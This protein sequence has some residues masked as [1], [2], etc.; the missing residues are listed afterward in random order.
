MVDVGGLGEQGMKLIL[1]QIV[2]A[3][4]G[5]LVPVQPRFWRHHNE[6]FSIV[7]QGLTTQYMV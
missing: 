5:C 3:R 4:I 7:H 2:Q 1:R 6:G